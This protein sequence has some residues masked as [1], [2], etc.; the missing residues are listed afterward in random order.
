MP[1]LDDSHAGHR[2]RLREQF[3]TSRAALI[4]ALLHA[5]FGIRP[6]PTES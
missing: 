4:G 2:T 3:F 1:D 6:H 5:R